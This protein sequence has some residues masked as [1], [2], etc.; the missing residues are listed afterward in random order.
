MTNLPADPLRA[1]CTRCVALC[2][3]ATNFAK[4]ADFAISKREGKACPNLDKTH[5]CSIHDGLRSKGFGGCVAFDCLGAGQRATTMASKDGALP[6]GNDRALHSLWRALLPL[7]ELLWALREGQR[8]ARSTL[9][10]EDPALAALQEEVAR[11]AEAPLKA[12][13]QELRTRTN[14]LLWKVSADVRQPPGPDHGRAMRIEAKL[15][16]RDLR[17]ANLFASCMLGADLRGADLRG[18]DL[19]GTDLRGADLRGADLRDVLFLQQAQVEGA[20]GDRKTRL[21]TGIDRPAHWG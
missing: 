3:V 13:A 19:R 5:Q 2:C 6:D 10:T 1:D 21:P 4:S 9:K 16:G 18:A 8:H 11:A 7:H 20:R 15:R 12:D 14:A 17:R